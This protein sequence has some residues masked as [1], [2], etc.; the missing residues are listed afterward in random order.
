MA[1]DNAKPSFL[2]SVMSGIGGY[3]KGALTGVTVGGLTG[4]GIGALVGIATGGVGAA[5]A[6][7]AALGAS[8]LGT[9]GAT[10]GTMTAIVRNRE[11]AQ[12]SADDVVKVA[13]ISFAQGVAVGHNLEQAAGQQAEMAETSKWRD[14]YAQE[15]AARAMGSPSQ[16]IH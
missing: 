6:L 11:A 16:S 4:A 15:Q 14:K 1:E 5:A 7:G 12:P 8:L 3:I 9:I 13:K 10:A 2:R